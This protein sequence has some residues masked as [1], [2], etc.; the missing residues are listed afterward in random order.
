MVVNNVTGGQ[1]LKEGCRTMRRRMEDH[2][3]WRNTLV[4]KVGGEGN[5]YK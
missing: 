3:Q 2:K 4:K 5:E 1:E